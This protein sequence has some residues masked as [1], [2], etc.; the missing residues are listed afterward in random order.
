M[1]TA[2]M[3]ADETR[4][5]LAEEI[6]VTANIRSPRI[7]DAI[8]SVPR[9]KFLPPGPW[10]IRG[11]ADVM[12]P[13]RQTD[14]ADPRHVYH[15]IAVAIDPSRQLYNGQPSLIA[16]WLEE[17]R[18]GEGQRVVHVGTG[19]GYFTALLAHIVG[20]TGRVHGI[21]IDP[22]LAQQASANLSPWPWVTVQHGNGAAELP[23]ENDFLLVHAGA[24][25]V[26][27]AW[28]DALRDGGRLLVPLTGSLSGFPDPNAAKLPPDAMRGNMPAGMKAAMMANIGKGFM[29]LVTRAGSDWIARPLPMIPVAI[30]SL[31]DV[32]DE[33]QGASLGQAMISGRLMKVTRLRRDRHDAGESCV[34]HGATTCLATD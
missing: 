24:T 34:V 27:D 14:D 6:R 12:G 21:E 3:T 25:H 17:A 32:R 1:T 11:M 15:D 26:L 4:R 20:P 30:Y 33:T 18:V 2:T 13:P 19:T 22:D 16:R 5:F 7:I 10:I 9:D 8:A 29:L 28:L 23:A 31:K